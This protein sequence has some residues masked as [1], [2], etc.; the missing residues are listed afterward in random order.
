[1]KR[2][3]Q[4][5]LFKLANAFYKNLQPHEDECKGLGLDGKR[6]FGN[7]FIEGDVLNIIGWEGES[8]VE[9]EHYTP[10]QLEYARVLFQ[11]D[12]LKYLQDMWEEFKILRRKS[13]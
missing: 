7:S 8:K 12:L 11:E 9:G 3:K 6:P 2:N 13:K 10:E 5:D 1:M 4:R